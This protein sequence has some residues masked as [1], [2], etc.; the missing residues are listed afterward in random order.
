MIKVNKCSANKYNFHLNADLLVCAQGRC[1][2]IQKLLLA[3]TI[4]HGG[5]C[6]K[7][8]AAGACSIYNIFD[9]KSL[10]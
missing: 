2:W 6:Q 10:Y 9:L 7:M 8:Q 1:M 3:D 4:N 5:T